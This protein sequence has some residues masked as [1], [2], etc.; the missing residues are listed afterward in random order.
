[1]TSTP[2]SVMSGQEEPGRHLLMLGLAGLALGACWAFFGEDIKKALYHF[3]VWEMDVLG[4]FNEEYVFLKNRLL[5]HPHAR[6]ED[7]GRC[8]GEI[9]ADTLRGPIAG[10]LFL[11]AF[12]AYGISLNKAHC[13]RHTLES[14]LKSLGRFWPACIPLALPSRKSQEEVFRKDALTAQE[15][16]ESKGILSPEASLTSLREVLVSDLGDLWRGVEGL[17]IYEKALLVL[18]GA[19]SL[20]NF[21]ERHKFKCHLAACWT[22]KDGFKASRFVRKAIQKSFKDAEFLKRLQ[23]ISSRHGYKGTVFMALL[24]EFRGQKGLLP[25]C[26]FL[27]LKG[28]NRPLWYALNNLGRRT[29]HVEALALM[30]H[31][32][33][34][35]HLG[36]KSAFPLLDSAASSL[37]KSFSAQK[38]VVS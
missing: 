8:M 2:S 25:S 1:M 18:F 10:L 12:W 6:L 29:F 32:Q 24:G 33:E 13:H 5:T 9:I 37:F 11:L 26:D 34:E 17:E 35:L 15:W 20:W 30:S 7:I 4:F 22:V 36:K 3:R 28:V 19:G 14:L 38:G 16:A 27:W 31:Y 21:E 23:D